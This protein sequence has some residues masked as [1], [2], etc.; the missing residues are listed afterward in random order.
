MVAVEGW[1]DWEQLRE[2]GRARMVNS[3]LVL[4]YWKVGQRTRQDI[5]QE[6]RAE[7]GKQILCTLSRELTE[8]FRPGFPRAICST[9]C[10]SQRSFR[11]SEM[12]HALSAQLTWP[13]SRQ[14]S[15]LKDELQHDR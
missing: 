3:A 8:E 1:V 13:H 15:Y 14:S 12:V 10:G 11:D 2:K 4:L 9:W 6:K 7:Y 5:L